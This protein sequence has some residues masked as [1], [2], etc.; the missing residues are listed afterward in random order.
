MH[1][2]SLAQGGR[3][4]RIQVWLL[5]RAL[6]LSCMAC[7]QGGEVRVSW[8][9]MGMGEWSLV[10]KVFGL[11]M[12]ALD[13]TTIGWLFVG[14]GEGLRGEGGEKEEGGG[15]WVGDGEKLGM[16]WGKEEIEDAGGLRIIREGICELVLVV[17]G[18]AGVV[19]LY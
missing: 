17:W 14:L 16:V 19:N 18:E 5:M 6:Y 1:P 8:T 12:L 15:I 11:N 2:T 7:N 4:V 3:E 9:V 13:L 10:W